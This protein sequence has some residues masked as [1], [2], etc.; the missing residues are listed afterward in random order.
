MILI[1][2]SGSTK[3]DWIAV[4]KNGN[5][6]FD[7]VRTKG[8]NPA[9]LS[10][11]EL[12]KN[13]KKS[14]VLME[15]KK[16]VTHI[17]FYGA[18]CGTSK[19]KKLLK[20]LLES[21]FK[22]AE[23]EVQE[24]TMAAVRATLN[25]KDE[26]AI[27]CI[28]GTGSN[29]SYY[30]GKDLHQ[31]VASLGYMIMDDASGN[32]FGKQLL[33]DYYYNHMPEDLKKSFVSEYNLEADYIKYNLYKKPN[34]NAYLASFAEFLFANKESKYISDLIK[35]GIRVF[36]KNMI[37]QFE[38]VLPKVPVHFAGSIAYF[39]QEEIKEV[40]NEMGFSL[41]NIEKRPIEGLLKYHINNIK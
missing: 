29:C 9:I 35:D 25:K 14:E 5:T 11:K 1:V 31:L 8:L 15:H 20:A 27:V 10:E 39:S 22:K 19:P 3:S 7:K 17:F 4:D 12:K 2:D 28:L 24:D 38:D 30:D 13:I 26:A 21:I 6:C 23:V 16:E 34:A 37:Y 40:A 18:G 41:G 36:A 33:R 32:Y